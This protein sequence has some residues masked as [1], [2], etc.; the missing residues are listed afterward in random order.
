MFTL[1]ARLFN[2]LYEGLMINDAMVNTELRDEKLNQESVI[3]DVIN[4]AID[5]KLIKLHIPGY[6][7]C[8][9]GT[10]TDF[11]VPGI[12]KLDEGCKAHDLSYSKNKD[13]ESRAEAD[14]VLAE[15]AWSRVKASDSTSGEKAAAWLVTNIMK[16]KSKLGAKRVKRCLSCKIQKIHETKNNSRNRKPV[17]RTTRHAKNV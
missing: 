16:A 17:T 1:Q 7:Y 12:N 13:S 11:S 10:D 4:K 3:G 15:H 5:K 2:K 14:R 6:R 8:G 9:P